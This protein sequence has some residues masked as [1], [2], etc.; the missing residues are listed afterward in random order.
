MIYTQKRTWLKYVQQIVLMCCAIPIVFT[1]GCVSV[2]KQ[3][4]TEGTK[5]LDLSKGSIV[6]LTVIT[7]NQFKP[8]WR[9]YPPLLDVLSERGS[10]IELSRTDIGKQIPSRLFATDSDVL[11]PQYLVSAQLPPGRHVLRHI[12]GVSE[13]ALVEGSF[14]IPLLL[15]FELPEGKIVHLG[16]IEAVNRPRSENE[17]RAGIVIPLIDQAVTGFA[18]G[19]FDVRVTPASQDDIALFKQRYPALQSR[20]IECVSLPSWDRRTKDDLDKAD[21]VENFHHWFSEKR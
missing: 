2:R 16:R 15:G 3:P 20:H 18:N 4:L 7:T 6:L 13:S 17:L 5:D 8:E 14:C 19:T 21:E 1:T 10:K 9:P 12:L 11:S